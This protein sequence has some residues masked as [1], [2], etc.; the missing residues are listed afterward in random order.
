MM[1]KPNKGS[2]LLIKKKTNKGSYPN[3][4]GNIFISATKL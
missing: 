1:Q 2:Y 4:A 3:R